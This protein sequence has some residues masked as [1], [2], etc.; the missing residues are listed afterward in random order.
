MAEAPPLD[1]S[2]PTYS[3][4]EQNS[5][6]KLHCETHLAL[7]GWFVS[8]TTPARGQLFINSVVSYDYD[9]VDVM[10]NK[11]YATMIDSFVNKLSV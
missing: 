2:S 5:Q 7:R 11:N 4:Q 9:A 8:P 3:C 10:D 6:W 1:P